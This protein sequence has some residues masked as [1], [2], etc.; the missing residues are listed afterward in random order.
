MLM[1]YKLEDLSL[2]LIFDDRILLYYNSNLITSI[3]TCLTAAISSILTILAV[4]VLLLQVN[5]DGGCSY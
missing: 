5:P 3:L 2:L 1:E 4:I